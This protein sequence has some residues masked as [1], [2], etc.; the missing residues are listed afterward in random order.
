[1]TSRIPASAPM[2]TQAKSRPSKRRVMTTSTPSMMPERGV[3]PPL[4]TFIRVGPMVPA[5]GIPPVRN[6]TMFPIPCPISSRSDLCLLR[7]RASST[8]QV[9]SVSID[10][11]TERV[12]AGTRMVWIDKR[13]RESRDVSLSATAP[14][15][16]PE[17][18]IG[19]IISGLP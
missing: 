5:P 14:K 11:R 8:T 19:P 18:L 12:R 16:E 4:V 15:K 7:V 17:A 6:D 1:M 3:R 13:L 10:K 2:G 9:F